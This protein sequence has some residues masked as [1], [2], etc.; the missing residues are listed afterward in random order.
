MCSTVA[1]L[2]ANALS[3]NV[4]A[5]CAPPADG[6]A[7]GC[8]DIC[9]Q[10]AHVA[11]QFGETA[12]STRPGL[13]RNGRAQFLHAAPA[14]HWRETGGTLADKDKEIWVRMGKFT[15]AGLTWAGGATGVFSMACVEKEG[16]SLAPQVGLE[17]TTLRLTAECSTIELLRSDGGL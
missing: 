1:G 3:P 14:K 12:R 10:S 17:P 9:E 6:I 4:E 7:V 2:Q 15:F 13:G 16:L 5:R 8:A 11:P